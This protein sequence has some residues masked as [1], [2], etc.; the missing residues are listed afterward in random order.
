[1]SLVVVSQ[2]VHVLP[3]KHYVGI[4]DSVEQFMAMLNAI[5]LKATLDQ[6]V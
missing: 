2:P 3:M 5:V 1:M 4:M 6:I